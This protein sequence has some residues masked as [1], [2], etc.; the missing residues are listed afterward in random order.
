MLADHNYSVCVHTFPELTYY[1][2]FAIDYKSITICRC[3]AC[4]IHFRIIYYYE[5]CTN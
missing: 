4:I 3:T 2:T 5:L 1:S